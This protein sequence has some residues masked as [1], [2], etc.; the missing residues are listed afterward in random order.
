M[1]QRKKYS[2]AD[3][4]DF[5]TNGD[6]SDLSDLSD[7]DEFLANENVNTD[8]CAAA[9]VDDN[10]DDDDDGDDDDIPLAALKKKH[11]YQ[12]VKKDLNSDYIDTSLCEHQFKDIPDKISSPFQYFKYFFTDELLQLIVENTNLYSTQKSGKCINTALDEISMLIGMQMLM[13]LVKLPAY[14]SFWSTSLRY[15]LIADNMPRNRYKL[16]RQNLHFVDNTTFLEDSGKLFK[17]APVIELIRKQCISL[18]PERFHAI[19]EQIIPSK[20]KY[21]K[22][23]QY[24]PK[25]P[26]KW[27]FK[28]M[29]RAGRSGM[30]YDFYLYAGKESTIP[31]EY[32]HLSVSA[33]SVAYLCMELPKHEDKVVFFD[34][35]FS[36]LDLIQYLKGI[37]IKGAGTF[38]PNRL[39][40]CPVIPSKE[41]KKKDRGSLDYRID[42]NSALIVVKWLDNSIVHLV[43]NCFGIAPL[44]TIYRWCS[45]TKEKK[46]RCFPI[47]SGS[48]Q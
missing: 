22:I 27:G 35:W 46:K 30:M 18:E 38:R 41:L 26:C 33:Q 15:P 4:I 43:S 28:N 25:K 5:V 6:V 24:N 11:E 31:A 13:G 47:Y 32:S 3:V 7:D 17:I 9:D 42:K 44:S 37:G 1:A 29:V 2:V 19:D 8:N 16:L 23:R 36:T 48:I 45:K 34:N 14:S 39:H 12:W 40:G 21:S 20:T 10:H